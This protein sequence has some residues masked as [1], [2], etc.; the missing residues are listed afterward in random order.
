MQCLL[1]GII[2]IIIILA[3]SFSLVVFAGTFL[4]S[5]WDFISVVSDGLHR[6]LSDSKSP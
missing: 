3:D 5:L 4:Y 1:H 2:I 6:C